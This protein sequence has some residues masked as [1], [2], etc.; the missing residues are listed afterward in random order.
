[1]L[2]HY[3]PFLLPSFFLILLLGFVPFLS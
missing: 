3:F 1:L 2:I